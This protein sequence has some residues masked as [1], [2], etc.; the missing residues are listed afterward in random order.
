MVPGPPRSWSWNKLPSDF[1]L[2][3][4]NLEHTELARLCTEEYEQRGFT[5]SVERQ[6]DFRLQLAVDDATGTVAQAIFHHT[7]DTRGY[8]VLL[9]GLVRQRGHSPGPIQ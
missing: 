6:N 7:E 3:R 5:V 8:L 2:T 4:Y 9:E 1:D